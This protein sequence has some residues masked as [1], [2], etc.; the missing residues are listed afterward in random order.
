MTSRT[1]DVGDSAYPTPAEEEEEGDEGAGED[2][3]DDYDGESPHSYGNHMTGD[4]VW[5]FNI[6]HME[7]NTDTNWIEY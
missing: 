2:H 7:W 6:F 5:Y 4:F 3:H 1:G